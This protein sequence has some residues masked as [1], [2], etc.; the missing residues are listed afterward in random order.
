MHGT[1][2]FPGIKDIQSAS[3]TLAHGIS[4]GRAVLT[5]AP[6]KKINPK[7]GTLTFKFGKRTVKI[8]DC[9]PLSASL[10]RNPQG[11]IT[12]VTLLDKRRKWG[13]GAI[14]GRYNQRDRRTGQIQ[15]RT[16]KT[17]AELAELCL[18]AM[19]EKNIDVAA[20]PLA[21]RPEVDWD[22]ETPA[23]ALSQLCADL[24][25]RVVMETGGKV[26]IVR[27]TRGPRL[28]AKD[29]ASDSLAEVAPELPSSIIVV[30]GP[31]RYQADFVLEAV[32]LEADGSVRLIDDLTYK[33]A[34]GWTQ[35]PADEFAAETDDKKKNAYR[36]SVYRMYRIKVNHPNGFG[37][38]PAYG[39]LVFLDQILPLSETQID[40]TLDDAGR[41]VAAPRE[42]WG[43]WTDKQEQAADANTETTLKS[44]AT[45]SGGSFYKR[46]FQIDNE[47]GIVV[48][49]QPV[50]QETSTGIAPAELALRTA[51][52]VRHASTRGLVRS[53]L[54]HRVGGQ[55]PPQ[56]IH[57]HALSVAIT[58]N[59]TR[60]DPPRIN[61]V[62][63]N[64]QIIDPLF[65]QFINRE[66]DILNG[67]AR[68]ESATYPGIEPI[69][70]DGYIQ[71]VTWSVSAGSPTITDVSANFDPG[72]VPE[73]DIGFVRQL[74]NSG[75]AYQELDRARSVATKIGEVVGAP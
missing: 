22:Y 73:I 44:H 33:P 36:T 29:V 50:Y 65:R 8:R 21:Q 49:S 12:Q 27:L 19:G 71:S 41:N 11:W 70:L 61:G 1:V 37:L 28:K 45:T 62:F 53:I 35:T 63:H 47:R 67:L 64:R 42:V 9:Y 7:P 75:V 51:V 26:K 5:V 24:G 2:S 25:C 17:P 74:R 3:Y 15:P 23:A 58:G 16:I 46:P 55:G 32:G 31:V 66:V 54:A 10:V 59:F 38:L 18:A 43:V 52:N 72:S 30:G 48:F 39:K 13:W 6:Q 60:L 57:Q 68:S 69:E 4:P 34:G 14:S 56:Y 40:T 20:L